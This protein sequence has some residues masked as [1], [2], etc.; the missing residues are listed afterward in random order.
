MEAMCSSTASAA[1]RG[2]DNEL[3]TA[4]K[5]EASFMRRGRIRN[6]RRYASGVGLF[7]KIG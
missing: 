3:P 1:R 2:T 6:A 5:S 7:S 4:K